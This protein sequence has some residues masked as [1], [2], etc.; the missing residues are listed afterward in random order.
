MFTSIVKK[1]NEKL[2]C[3]YNE[4]IVLQVQG[5]YKIFSS[6]NA[7][8]FIKMLVLFTAVFHFQLTIAS[9]V[10]IKVLSRIEM[11]SIINHEWKIAFLNSLKGESISE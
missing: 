1:T 2:D 6:Q 10:E 8:R 9:I 11:F 4:I 7:K 3:N 5:K